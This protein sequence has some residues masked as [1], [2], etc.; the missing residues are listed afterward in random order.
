M[1]SRPPLTRRD[2]LRAAALAALA[3][4]TA[5][6]CGAGYETGPDPLR[7]LLE[8]AR[9]D[10]AAAGALARSAPEHAQLAG[11]V[12][13]ARSA[14]ADALQAEVD[15]LNRPV[16]EEPLPAPAPHVDGL[17]ALG[18]RLAD[19]DTEAAALVPRLPRH[20]AG[21][22]GSVAA[23]CASL[24]QLAPELG[25]GP[26]GE[27]GLNVEAGPLPQESVL[28]LQDALAA[29]HA[30][31]WVYGLVRAFL[32]GAYTRGLDA[33]AADHRDRRDACERV[34][35]AAGATPRPSEPAYVPPEPVTDEDSAGKVVVAA[36]TDAARA[37][38]GVLERTDDAGLRT[39][40]MRALTGSA[41]RC[42]S[43]R[44]EAGQEPAAIA[45][46]GR[47]GAPDS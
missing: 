38:H 47:S 20:R 35:T 37:W 8:R 43:W 2:V 12:A 26:A 17:E 32:P 24:R 25:A 9:A 16:P 7:P 40:A 23:G 1:S 29:E 3:V 27:V 14:H 30:A 39:L 6:A 36:E 4:S 34:L 45:L 13:T 18:R 11:Q 19:A 46:P 21:L 22:V 5:S 10:A 33:G 31:V 44:A 15:R 41:T 28:A 42:T